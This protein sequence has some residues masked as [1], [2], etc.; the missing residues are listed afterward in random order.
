M[1]DMQVRS[2]GQEDPLEKEMATHPGI[3]AR[4]IPRTE[5]SG[6]LGGANG[7]EPACQCRRHKGCGCGPWVGRSPE[8]GMATD[9]NI[10][11]WRIPWTEELAGTQSIGSQPRNRT[12][13]S[14]V[15]LMPPALAGGFFTPGVTWDALDCAVFHSVL[16]H[17]LWECSCYSVSCPA[18][19]PLRLGAEQGLWTHSQPA[20]NRGLPT[21]RWMSHITSGCS[22][23]VRP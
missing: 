8:E 23:S 4:R 1:Q 16:N 13:L 14:Y 5:Y 9:S 17:L 18:E 11:A 3:L 21:A 6:I 10:L 7:K 15:S 2:L 22:S 12:S 19:G 20:R